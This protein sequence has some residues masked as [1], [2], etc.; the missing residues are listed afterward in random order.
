ME[1]EVSGLYFINDNFTFDY[2]LAYQRGKKDK[3]LKNQSDKDLADINPLKMNLGLTYEQNKHLLKVDVQASDSWDKFDSDNGEQKLSGYAL[4]NLKYNNKLSKNFD[5]TFGMDNVFDK[6]YAS[7]N[8]Y[9]DLTLISAGGSDT[10]LLNNPG[11]Y[12]YTNIRYRF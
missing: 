10:M 4:L 6:N 9:K 1:L 5:I 12:I 11:R 3:V 2:S 8:T 7:S